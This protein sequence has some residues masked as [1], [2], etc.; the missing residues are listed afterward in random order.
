M[1]R[2]E[3][4][5]V[6]RLD[7]CAEVLPGFSVRGRIEHHSAG[8]HQL[9]LTRQLTE[10][11]PYVYEPAHKLRI[12]PGRDAAMYEVKPGDVL[13][14]SRGTRN[15]AWE[16]REVPAHTLAPVSFYILR[17]RDS[18]D[19][20]YLA[21]YL[22]QP[23]AQL[24]IEQIRTGAGTPIV[25]R[26]AFQ[27]LEIAVPPHATQ[28]RIAELAALL[29]RERQLVARMAGTVA[30][31]HTAIGRQIIENLRSGGAHEETQ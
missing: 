31:A 18:M 1:G 23:P 17:P 7:E 24:A 3:A 10:G 6:N 22:N 8:T 21:W 9:L 4:M 14:M 30:Q 2:A 27:E 29:A 28:Q 19:P 5:R 13:F 12:V 15:L 11:V 20:G 26:R 25:Q 16:I